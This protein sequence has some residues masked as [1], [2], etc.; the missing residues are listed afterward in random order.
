[1]QILGALTGI[2]LAPGDLLALLDGCVLPEPR[3]ESGASYGKG[4]AS[5]RLA[6]QGTIYLQRAGQGWQVRGAARQGWQ[7]EYRAWL[8]DF[9]RVVR[10]TST[11]VDLTAQVSQLETNV[12]LRPEAFDVKVPASATS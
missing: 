8:G 10:L 5:L 1:D 9:P 6:G 4:W 3:V 7:V 11:D 12:T 2:A